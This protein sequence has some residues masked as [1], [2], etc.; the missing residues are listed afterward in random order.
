MAGA[1]DLQDPAPQQ[2]SDHRPALPIG[3][4][5]TPDT[6]KE[7]RDS[8]IL[9]L[10]QLRSQLVT[11]SAQ[12]TSAHPDVIEVKQQIADLKVR[13]DQLS[14]S[15]IH[16]NA[17]PREEVFPPRQEVRESI[18][19]KPMADS[20]GTALPNRDIAA[21]EKAELTETAR[22]LAV[23]LDS[24]RVVVGKAQTAINNPRLEDKGFSLAVFEE[25]LRKEFLTRSGHDLRS[26]APAQMPE[27]AKVLL[28]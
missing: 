13:L 8:L 27:R 9:S 16:P 2:L 6:L 7:K 12:Y 1:I 26:L 20:E 10:H 21:E 11:L 17:T 5:Q 24:G 14:G 19:S 23:L 28:V 3:D 15:E 4:P 22:L 18:A 25:R